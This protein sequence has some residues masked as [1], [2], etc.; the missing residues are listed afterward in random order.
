MILTRC[1]LLQDYSPHIVATQNYQ[2]GHWTDVSFGDYYANVYDEQTKL[3]DIENEEMLKYNFCSYGHRTVTVVD[4][5][6]DQHQS[7]RQSTINIEIYYLG[8]DVRSHL[9]QTILLFLV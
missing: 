1:F 5:V 3:G 9:H 2:H 6:I 4:K 7:H 8:G